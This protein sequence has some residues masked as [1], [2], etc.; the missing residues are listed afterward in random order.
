MHQRWNDSI[1]RFEIA[2][3]RLLPQQTTTLQRRLTLA[4]F[5]KDNFL[6]WLQNETAYSDWCCNVTAIFDFLAAEHLSDQKKNYFWTSWMFFGISRNNIFWPVWKFSR[7]SYYRY[8]HSKHVFCVLS[9]EIRSARFVVVYFLLQQWNTQVQ[10]RLAAVYNVN[11]FIQFFW[12]LTDFI[13]CRLSYKRMTIKY[14]TS[15]FETKDPSLITAQFP[16]KVTGKNCEHVNI[17]LFST[18]KLW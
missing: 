13:I 18:T 11:T 8:W 5:I 4:I 1:L 12:S 9:N 2:M 17:K 3:I 10:F 7:C 15:C 14:N 6:F 16:L